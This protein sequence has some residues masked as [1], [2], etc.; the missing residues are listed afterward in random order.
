MKAVIKKISDIINKAEDGQVGMM[1]AVC[2]L[3]DMVKPLEEALKAIKD[4]KDEHVD[5]FAMLKEEYPDGFGGYT[6][7]YRNGSR[8][9]NYKGI[10]EVDNAEKK[11]KELKEYYKQAFVSATKGIIPVSEDGEQL[12]LPEP[13]YGKACIILKPIKR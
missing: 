12:T 4:F 8:R 2:D 7:E 13:S 6:F 5:E 11:V 10:K 3:Q 1:E 9:L